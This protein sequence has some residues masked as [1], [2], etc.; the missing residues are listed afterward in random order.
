MWSKSDTC[1]QSIYVSK[2][3]FQEILPYNYIKKAS[4]KCLLLFIELN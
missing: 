3:K 1:E 4:G 2:Y